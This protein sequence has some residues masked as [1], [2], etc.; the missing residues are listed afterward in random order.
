M[1]QTKGED[2]PDMKEAM[3]LHAMV[4]QKLAGKS[5]KVKKHMTKAGKLLGQTSRD[6]QRALDR[7]RLRAAVAQ[8]KDQAETETSASQVVAHVTFR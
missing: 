5:K 6:V 4:D 2:D 1:A 7:L 8:V 3:R